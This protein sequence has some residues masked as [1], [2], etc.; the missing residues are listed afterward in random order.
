MELHRY[1]AGHAF[2]NWDAPSMYQEAA[3]T[4]AWARTTAFFAQHLG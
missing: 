4:E 3:A 1:A 2:S